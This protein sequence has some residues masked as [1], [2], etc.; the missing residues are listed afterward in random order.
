VNGSKRLTP[1]LRDWAE[2][3]ERGTAEN[4]QAFADALLRACEG[5]SDEVLRALPAL[6]DGAAAALAETPL[7]D[8]IDGAYL[9]W[10]WLEPF[11]THVGLPVA[12]LPDG[13]D[14]SDGEDVYWCPLVMLADE[15]DVP[16]DMRPFVRVDQIRKWPQQVVESPE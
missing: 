3:A 14:I 12:E 4:G 6:P 2:L 5:L 15:P 7:A 8:R 11:V 9:P 16:G 10:E 1:L 13:W